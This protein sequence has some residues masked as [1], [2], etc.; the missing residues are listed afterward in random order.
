MVEMAVLQCSTLE[1]SECKKE[2]NM[3]GFDPCLFLNTGCWNV[4]KINE[5]IGVLMEEKGYSAAFDQVLS[6][7]RN[8][9]GSFKELCDQRDERNQ[10]IQTRIAEQQEFELSEFGVIDGWKSTPSIM[11]ENVVVRVA[12]PAFR[13]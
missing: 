3:K 12:S 10:E 11:K 4:T 7:S 2:E 6:E 9:T 1:V 5:Q 8:V 13:I